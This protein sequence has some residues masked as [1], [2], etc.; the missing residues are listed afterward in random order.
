MNIADV[1]A[2]RL[3]LVRAGYTPI[4][5]Y[6]KVPP[7]KKNNSRKSFTDWEQV[8]NVT[9]EMLEMWEQVWP[10]ARNTGVLTRDMPTIDI[11]I[12]NEDAVRALERHVRDRFDDRG[13]VLVRTGKPP[14]KAVPFRIDG[15]DVFDKFVVNLDAP[16]GTQEK[17]EFLANGAQVVVAGTH[18]E[19]GGLYTWHGGELGNTRRADLPPINDEEAHNLVD[20]LVQILVE[21]FGYT[22]AKSRKP[23]KTNGAAPA[24]AAQDWQDLLHNIQAGR[25]LHDSIRDL[26]AKMVRSGMKAGAAVNALRALMNNSKAPRD[27]RWQERYDDILRQ[28]RTAE[29]LIERETEQRTALALPPTTPPPPTGPTPP[30]GQASPQPQPQPQQPQS[31]PLPLIRLIDGQLVQNI[32]AAEDALIAAG[33]RHTYQRGDLLVR[34][35]KSQ[36]RAANDRYTFLWQLFPLSRPFMVETFMRVAHFE[37]MDRR[38][39]RYVPKDCP[40]KLAE[41]YL[42]R[43]GHWRLPVLLGMVNAPFLRPDGTL[44]EQLGYDPASK[45]LFVSDGQTFDPIPA[46]PTEADAR[47][48]L[49]CLDETLLEEFPFIENIDRSVALSLL[50][51]AL[52]RR[53]MATA[54]LH[55]F[56]S[57][58]AGTGKS[59]LVDLASILETGD[60]APVIS[61]GKNEEELE[62]RLGAALI[63][64]DQIISLDNCNRELD[65]IFLCQALTQERLKIRMLGF[66]RHVDT[67]VTTLFCAT[68]NNLVIADDLTRRTLLCR[69]DAGVERPELRSFK[70]DVLE[71]ARSQRGKLVAAALTTLRA[72]HIASA[73]IAIG[74]DPLGSFEDWS[75]RIR[76]PL[77][78]LGYMDPCESIATVRDNDPNRTL[79][80]AVL[81]QWKRCL[82]V[83][84][85]HSIQ[86]VITRAIPDMD[87]FNALMAVAADRQGGLSNRRLGRWLSQNNGKIVGR[88]KLANKGLS[89]GYQLWQVI[90]A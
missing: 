12:L 30:T 13:P 20:E 24:D 63:A 3:R 48:A 16:N 18:P 90:E 59:L 80:I 51:T 10:D 47:T 1:T 79:L 23:R 33:G 89:A 53:S 31:Q 36:L 68:G 9:R 15:A 19:T 72:W 14:K 45:L 11:D 83:L 25:E 87:F 88:L 66:S 69:L 17:I 54:P 26:A 70:R 78:W 84:S 29:E 22:R 85:S 34:P 43:V 6:G 58:V 65:S 39:G 37:K 44:C 32:T 5:L 64:G 73:N 46:N 28:V 76:L 7:N 38:A 8:S 35:V 4:P 82:G 40:D 21:Q 71:T 60:R 57:P 2:L 67:P 52:D 81:E 42:S 75:F 86:Q 61:L 77:L 49:K 56:T 50:L 55:G 27:D 74:V 62:K 41:S